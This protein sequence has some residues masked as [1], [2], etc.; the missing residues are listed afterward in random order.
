MKV[1]ISTVIPFIFMLSLYM[2]SISSFFKAD[3]VKRAEYAEFSCDHCDQWNNWHYAASFLLLF[4]IGFTIG[5]YKWSSHS[6]DDND[7]E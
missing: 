2:A 5:L 4:A 1:R 7:E 3:E 6:E